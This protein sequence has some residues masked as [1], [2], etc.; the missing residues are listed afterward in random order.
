MADK[1]D[2]SEFEKSMIKSYDATRE[3]ITNNNINSMYEIL[4]W[5]V[6][7][8]NELKIS[9]VQRNEIMSDVKKE[10]KL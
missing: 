4:G 7:G 10:F 3:G 1:F 6:D 2:R 9:E 8:R 5:Y